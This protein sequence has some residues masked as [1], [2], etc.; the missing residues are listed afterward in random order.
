[1]LLH[2]HIEAFSAPMPKVYLN[3][4]RIN[5]SKECCGELFDFAFETECD[6]SKLTEVPLFLLARASKDNTVFSLSFLTEN[7]D[8]VYQEAFTQYFNF[9]LN[10]VNTL[11]KREIL[12]RQTLLINLGLIEKWQQEHIEKYHPTDEEVGG[13]LLQSI[14][15]PQNIEKKFSHLE[16]RGNELLTQTYPTNSAKENFANKG[17]LIERLIRAL[18]DKQDLFKQRK[19]FSELVDLQ[20]VESYHSLVITLLL[21]TLPFGAKTS[22]FRSIDESKSRVHLILNGN[23]S[24]GG[25]I[26]STI[27]TQLDYDNEKIIKS[28]LNELAEY[29]DQAFKLMLTSENALVRN[30]QKIIA[31]LEKAKEKYQSLA[32][33]WLLTNENSIHFS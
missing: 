28:T 17:L 25:K 22:K 5:G 26:I 16:R 8:G 6:L 21:A 30:R 29:I 18:S 13:G 14:K 10:E 11:F 15:S 2:F 12:N 3:S 20:D 27:S 4:Q 9:N 31:E 33:I 23:A 24:L 1:M 32:M 19:I 7:A